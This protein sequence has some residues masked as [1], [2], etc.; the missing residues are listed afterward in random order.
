MLVGAEI[1][2]ES[3]RDEPASP[4]APP[5]RVSRPKLQ[6]AV[7]VIVPALF[8][9]GR[10]TASAQELRVCGCWAMGS[11]AHTADFRHGHGARTAVAGRRSGGRTFRAVRASEP[12]SRLAES[13]DDSSNLLFQTLADWNHQLKHSGIDLESAADSG[14]DPVPPA[15]RKAARPA[16]PTIV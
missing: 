1:G 13:S 10:P 3:A 5:C 7:Q 15:R 2:P 16:S 6:H 4:I 9:S 14:P 8:L 12:S 11:L